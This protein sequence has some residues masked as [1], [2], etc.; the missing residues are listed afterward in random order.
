MLNRCMDP[1]FPR[2]CRDK[3]RR[4]GLQGDR[5]HGVNLGGGRTA[6]SPARYDLH[7]TTPSHADG[8][9]VRM[10]A[11]CQRVLA[12]LDALWEERGARAGP[13]GTLV[14]HSP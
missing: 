6:G 12:E 2:V 10:F 9:W 14:I 13:S 4:G 7:R 5:L 3:R 8:R 11:R 1:A